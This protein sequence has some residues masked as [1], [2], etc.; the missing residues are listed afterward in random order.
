MKNKIVVALSCLCI[1][2]AVGLGVAT[3]Q[4]MEAR[5]T[6][7]KQERQLKELYGQVNELTLQYVDVVKRIN[8]HGGQGQ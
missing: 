3:H 5:A 6:I 2:L 1:A 8:R 4:L 7:D